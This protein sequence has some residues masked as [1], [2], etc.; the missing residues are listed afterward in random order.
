MHFF[1]FFGWGGKMEKSFIDF[2][3]DSPRTSLGIPVKTKK[4]PLLNQYT[5][6]GTAFRLQTSRAVGFSLKSRTTLS[7]SVRTGPSSAAT[8][9]L[10]KLTSG[11][12]Q[13]KTK[14]IPPPNDAHSRI[15]P[16]R[17]VTG[18]GPDAISTGPPR[19]FAL[20]AHRALSSSSQ[21]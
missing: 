5:A 17:R 8:R 13:E 18:E 20:H 7:S 4:N 11:T 16:R 2:V 12:G 15:R 9:E 14:N 1:F 21:V 3:Q 10:G 19:C 6:H